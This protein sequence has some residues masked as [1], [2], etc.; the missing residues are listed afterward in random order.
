MPT[1]PT[2]A[3]PT[4][5]APA[6]N[7]DTS[8]QIVMPTLPVGA[9]FL[10]LQRSVANASNQPTT[11]DTYPQ[12]RL[13]GESFIVSRLARDT[14]YLWRTQ[15][16]FGD[17]VDAQTTVS[18][19]FVLSRTEG[20]PPTGNLTLTATTVSTTQINLAYSAQLLTPS[21]ATAGL[22]PTLQ[23]QRSP[24]VTPEVWTTIATPALTA[25]AATGTFNDT[26][27]VLDTGYRYRLVLG[28]PS[29]T[30]PTAPI[31]ART[32]PLSPAAPGRVTFDNPGGTFHTVIAPA[33]MPATATSL[34]LGWKLST[35]ADA[36]PWNM[37][38]S[39]PSVIKE[40]ATNENFE[41]TN[42]VLDTSYQYAFFAFNANATPTRGDIAGIKTETS[43]PPF[44]LQVP[45][46]P[47]APTLAVVAPPALNPTNS[48]IKIK[49]SAWDTTRLSAVASME[50][51]RKNTQTGVFTTI[52]TWS[53]PN[54]TFD[55]VGSFAGGSFEYSVRSLNAAGASAWSAPLIVSRISPTATVAWVTTTG[56]VSGVIQLVAQSTAPN[57]RIEYSGMA[58]LTTI[59]PA[60]AQQR[61]SMFDTAQ[62][63]WQGAQTF[64][65]VAIDVNGLESLPVVLNLNFA[66]TLV[67]N[68][69]WTQ[70][71]RAVGANETVHSVIV[72]ALID[73][74]K[75]NTS[76]RSKRLI[77][78]GIQS[79]ASAALLE[80][81]TTAQLEALETDWKNWTKIPIGKVVKPSGTRQSDGTF[82]NQNNTVALRIAERPLEM[83]TKT[84]LAFP[85][86]K[87]RRIKDDEVWIFALPKIYRFTK[88]G[89][90][91]LFDLADYQA[92][93]SLDA[94]VAGDKIHCITPDNKLLVID[95]T[96]GDASEPRAP[97]GETKPLAFVE[98]FGEFVLHVYSDATDTSVYKR[99]STDLKQVWTSPSRVIKSHANATTLA[100]AMNDG[101]IVTI[102]DTTSSTRWTF[103]IANTC[104]FVHLEKDGT[105]FVGATQSGTRSLWQIAIAVGSS[106]Q[107]IQIGSTFD[108]RDAV[109][110]QGAASSQRVAAGGNDAQLHVQ[111]P[112][113]GSLLLPQ[114]SFAPGTITHLERLE[115]TRAAG[116]AGNGI[117]IGT[118]AQ[119]DESLL[120]FV[121]EAGSQYV[122]RLQ[123]TPRGEFTYEGVGVSAQFDVVQSLPK[124]TTT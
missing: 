92:A 122:A 98:Q 52:T 113:P 27:R 112:L 83:L 6:T 78:F 57:V 68:T 82:A 58:L 56:T 32:W 29:G 14:V 7:R 100:L 42:R 70:T 77:E 54:Q 3:V 34:R 87:V 13:A 114:R 21:P 105:L 93:D 55:D 5:T 51:R 47:N 26:A 74:W 62:A 90:A 117:Q 115:I 65:A 12:Q 31:V 38:E 64:R 59:N 22:V 1:Y 37:A 118:P 36:A 10:R 4:V 45:P 124:T 44:T 123:Q 33:T 2:P 86:T 111:Q 120:I 61:I 24:D 15:A 116:T 9:A 110:Y 95:T 101:K 39:A 102:A 46:T 63:E 20:D 94:A 71:T 108:W 76:T 79:P 104:L 11:W 25:G 73:S 67:N 85:V 49:A 75:P 53:T 88:D 72:N 40:W 80:N 60:N 81:P 97:R 121:Q 41:I 66:N 91:Q 50:L 19:T 84:A 106:P 43:D 16:V 28:V 30:L 96:L 48:S 109:F 35:D 69:S 99:T 23:L 17:S 18:T 103:P 8:R 107:P 119:L 89:L